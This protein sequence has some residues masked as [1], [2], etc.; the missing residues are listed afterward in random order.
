MSEPVDAVPTV[1]ELRRVLELAHVVAR[2]ETRRLDGADIPEAMLSV[3]RQDQLPPAAHSM[4]RDALDRDE[5]F[6]ARVATLADER[7]VGLAGWLWLVRPD[8][9]RAQLDE[10]VGRTDPARLAGLE[11]E[12]AT[13]RERADV[14]ERSAASSQ[15]Q[16]TAARDEIAALEQ[17]L[18]EQ[19]ELTDVAERESERR[20]ARAAELEQRLTTA[21]AR[22][23]EA[24]AA[25]RSTPTPADD[26]TAQPVTA[27]PVVS[28]PDVPAPT[29]RRPRRSPNGL[30]DDSPAGF[31]ELLRVPGVRV[32]VDGYNVTKLAWPRLSLQLQ[33]ERLA[34]SIGSLVTGR[35]VIDVVYDGDDAVVA[36]SMRTPASLRVT[37]S[38]T[39]VTADDV[40]LRLADRIDPAVAVVVVSN[41]REVVTGA[42][43]LGANTVSSH[44]FVQWLG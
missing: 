2:A 36:A 8:G 22:L 39:G 9:W 33:R 41:D 28:T 26:T 34:S 13:Q 10:V 25:A 17:L 5:Q 42:K 18:A 32:L 23:G 20:R 29:R 44:S 27:A 31:A 37:W 11:A 4:V 14:A 30:L 3:V 12:V 7:E 35:A 38:P 19:V 16:L 43:R 15:R 6:R 1:A 24:R 40:I 21:E